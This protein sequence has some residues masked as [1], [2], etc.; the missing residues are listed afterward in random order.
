MNKTVVEKQ[1]TKEFI[2]IKTND[3]E[4][5]KEI[6]ITNII[7]SMGM[8]ANIKGY[9]YIR[10]A[11]KSVME[12]VN[13]INKIT[14]VLYP[15]IADKYKTISS[16]VERYIRTAITITFDRGNKN[17]LEKYFDEK[18]ITGNKRPKNSEFIAIIADKINLELEL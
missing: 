13:N 4:K 7:H 2:E 10:D 3:K 1:I 9:Y 8:P 15:E 17:I 18:Y 6:I 12:N 5:Q 16:K 11:I 14:K